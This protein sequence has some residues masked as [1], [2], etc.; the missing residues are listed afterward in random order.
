MPTAPA[1]APAPAPISKTQQKQENSTRAESHGAFKK[2]RHT[3]AQDFG[4]KA[5]SHWQHFRKRP[6]FEPLA[7]TALNAY[8]VDLL[9]EPSQLR[10]GP[11][12]EQGG[13][14]TERGQPYATYHH[15]HYSLGDWIPLATP[16]VNHFKS[17]FGNCL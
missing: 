6:R 2:K 15:M 8:P 4:P 7:E 1:L 16:Q 10:G 13:H 3:A 14:Y 12:T 11:Y 9:H 17:L 5:Q